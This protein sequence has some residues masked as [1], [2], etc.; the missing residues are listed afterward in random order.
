MVKVE[1]GER[2]NYVS[3]P[4]RTLKLK[5]HTAVLVL[6]IRSIPLILSTLSTEASLLSKVSNAIEDV[7]RELIIMQSVLIDADKKG[8]GSEGA[9][10]WLAT[11][12]D[13]VYDVEDVI[14]KFMYQINRER[15][16]GQSASSLQKIYGR[17]I[18]PPASYK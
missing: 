18:K 6:L 2:K 17:G 15:I 3:R 13:I 9:K 4:E 10:A 11:V 7:K 5:M 8:A 1:E 16:G 14:D 12:T